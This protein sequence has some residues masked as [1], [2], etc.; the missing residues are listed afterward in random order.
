MTDSSRRALLLSRLAQGS[1]LAVVL[2]ILFGG[3][4]RFGIWDPWELTAADAARHALEGEPLDET[5]PTMGT[6]L[7]ALGFR[8]FDVH[9]WS[10]RLPLAV[11]G[12]LTLVVATLLV[13]R[14]VD[15]RA[16]V[17]AAIALSTSPLFLL[18]A[19]Q[20]VGS[21]HE[22][23]ATA[24][25]FACAFLAV[26]PGEEKL[27]ER[28]RLSALA[29]LLPAAWIA[30]QASGVM[31]GV[32]P[33]LL[34]VTAIVIARREELVRGTPMARGA[35]A[36]VSVLGVGT[37][38]MVV[39]A[40]AMNAEGYSAWIGG[41]PHAGTPPTFEVD[42]EHVF[43]SA[44]PWSAV[45]PMAL[46]LLMTRAAAGVR[47]AAIGEAERK[48][49]GY[50]DDADTKTE[51]SE[52][53]EDA[54]TDREWA[55][56]AALVVWA[57][58]GYAAETV[59]TSRYG[60]A[61]FL[62]VVALAGI[63]A[64]YLRAVERD[65]RGSWAAGLVTLL[66]S[67]LLLRDY[68]FYPGVPASGLG[69]SD[70]V[71][72]EVFNP[73]RRWAI[74]LLGFGAMAFLGLSTDRTESFDALRSQLSLEGTRLASLPAPLRYLIGAVRAGVPDGL[75]RAQWARGFGYR[76]WI[77][78]I[79]GALVCFFG[80]G[81]LCWTMPD[82]RPTG[83]L[84]ASGG[85][86]NGLGLLAGLLSLFVGRSDR[87]RF[88]R[89]RLGARIGA[90]L[91]LGFA[92]GSLVLSSASLSSLGVLVGKALLFVPFGIVLAIA[93]VRLL[94]F[95][96][97]SLGENALVPML[98]AGL[99][100]G[101]YVSF[102]FEPE[103][104]THFSPREI[105][106]T[107]NALAQDGEP[108]GEYRVG[109]RAAAYYAQGPVEEVTDEASAIQFLA[110]PSRVWL[111]F[112]ADDL[113]S[114][115]RAWRRHSTAD[116]HPG[117]HLFVADARS[118][119][120]LLATNQPIS[121]RADENYLRDAILDAP[122]STMQHEV[123]CNFDR[124][125]ELVGYDLETPRPG[126]AGPGQAFTVTWYW[127]A[128]APVPAGYQIFL[129][130][131]GYGQRLNGDHEPVQGHY[132]VRLWDEG[133]IVVDRQEMRVPA[134]FPAGTYQ[135]FIGFYSGESRLEILEG[136]EDDVNRCIAGPLEVR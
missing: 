9:E 66:L 28:V 88:A 62:P 42:L 106:D 125:V 81:V 127:R 14:I 41:T 93:A 115:D 64:I 109:G 91:M 46:G 68:R 32:A 47:A 75:V 129:H 82:E 89:F 86:L 16:G 85:V 7:V 116:G 4:S 49:L 65:G 44:A 36:A 99:A 74:A 136:H 43:H 103:L 94:R 112:R 67:A 121:G 11:A 40:I 128:I 124:R 26:F 8:L 97:Y 25:V 13:W 38:L 55:L 3:L 122:P 56:G 15:R 104:S 105:Y 29:G 118:A 60:T 111:A 57:G 101:G 21:A 6:R 92:Q 39:R 37:A 58:A 131:D 52:P 134:N 12:L 19:R 30:A 63:V 1:A 22:F 33:P 96:F 17:Y 80:F 77:G 10:G 132:P 78:V 107:Y 71:A 5:Q 133:D 114:L 23:L 90:L 2:A 126:V 20:M 54:A 35:A 24:L 119:R 100:F 120:V 110:R 31:L 98:V 76:V 27:A 50:R 135:F 123:H 84:L 117:G 72:P 130:V 113:A 70:L 18:N 48:A 51:T 79:A 83:A 34:G 95:A 108:L 45:L 73:S 53:A 61:T 59:F 102:G 69:L 87:A